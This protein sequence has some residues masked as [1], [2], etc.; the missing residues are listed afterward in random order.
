MRVQT[1]LGIVNT[2]QLANA[3]SKLSRM[4]NDLAYQAQQAFSQAQRQLQVEQVRQLI[5]DA[6]V[7]WEEIENI[8]TTDPIQAYVFSRST[9]N[10]LQNISPEMLPEISD[11]EYLHK[12]SKYANSIN[13]NLERTLGQVA[14]IKIDRSEELGEI[15]KQLS[16]MIFLVSSL[17]HVRSSFFG[18]AKKLRK[19]GLEQ[20][21]NVA[22]EYG[23]SELLENGQSLIEKYQNGRVKKSV[24]INEIKAQAKLMRG[25]GMDFIDKYLLTSLPHEIRLKNDIHGL[26]PMLEE[27]K[28]EQATI[29]NDLLPGTTPAS[30]A[31][32]ANT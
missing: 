9:N 20:V 12:V 8:A 22:D 6:R 14:L 31:A 11:K 7:Q 4:Q 28:S 17:D 15:I 1:A 13:A 10:L 18:G 3:N 2:I 24:L 32:L 5:F 25:N 23:I 30:E 26:D 27:A 21:L 16:Y 19:K 29:I